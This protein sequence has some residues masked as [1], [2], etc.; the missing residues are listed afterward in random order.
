MNFRVFL[1]YQIE[2]SYASFPFIQYTS[3]HGCQIVITNF[4]PFYYQI[5][6]R[7]DFSFS[8]RQI[9]WTWLNMQVE[10]PSEIV[11]FLN[12]RYGIL[13]Q[14]VF[15]KV[16]Y[17]KKCG[18]LWFWISK[19]WRIP[20]KFF[21]S[22]FRHEKKNLQKQFKW[23]SQFICNLLQTSVLLRNRLTLSIFKVT[24]LATAKWFYFLKKILQLQLIVK[25]HLNLVYLYCFFIIGKNAIYRAIHLC[26][27]GRLYQNLV[28]Q[29]KIL[30]ITVMK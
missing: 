15:F 9:P 7:Y 18:T 30:A 28:R 29:D 13:H 14:Y 26:I 21:L 4:L 17:K 19:A 23:T 27:I 3:Q 10:V 20:T 16:F 22:R 8:Y 1:T 11:I 6:F 2:K 5:F 24:R 25:R 12:D